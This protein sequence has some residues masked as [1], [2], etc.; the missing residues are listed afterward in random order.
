MARVLNLLV[1]GHVHVH[2]EQISPASAATDP[3]DD[4]SGPTPWFPL[5]ERT[6]RPTVE[7][8]REPVADPPTL[9]AN[10]KVA[11]QAA[12]LRSAASAGIPACQICQ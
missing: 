1:S 7:A 4:S 12:A 9:P 11:A 8:F 5:P 10:T 3:A 6:P 2:I